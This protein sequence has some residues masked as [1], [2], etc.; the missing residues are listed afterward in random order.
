MSDSETALPESPDT[1]GSNRKRGILWRKLPYLL[2]LA[3]AIVGVAYTSFSNRPLYGYWEFLALAVGV[4]CVAIGWRNAKDRQARIRVVVRQ[5]LHWSAF[6]L[7]MNIVLFR[8]FAS[9]LNAPATGLALMLL[10]ALGTFVAGIYISV[11]IAL[12]GVLLGLMVP[13][14]AWLKQAVLLL[15]LVGF[16]VGGLAWAVWGRSSGE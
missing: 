13:A 6:L 2:V 16:A 12:L 14:L 5:A 4:A 1:S 15:L 3:L 11:D 7:A 8:S 9:F 10:L